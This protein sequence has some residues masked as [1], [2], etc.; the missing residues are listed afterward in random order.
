MTS[1]LSPDFLEKPD[2]VQ[3]ESKTVLGK[4]YRRLKYEGKN[5][6]GR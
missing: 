4:I 6:L 3:Y 1:A 5:E 2:R